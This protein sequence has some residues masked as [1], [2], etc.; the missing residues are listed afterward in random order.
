MSNP[1]HHAPSD[2]PI[3]TRWNVT[4]W[5]DS[6]RARDRE[7]R[8]WV[9]I[10]LVIGIIFTAFPT[11]DTWVSGVF[12][13]WHD[14]SW[15]H[16]IDW[17]MWIYKAVPWFGR[18]ALLWGLFC[19]FAPA[20]W[21]GGTRLKRR[22]AILGLTMFLLVGAAVNGGFKSYWGRA[23]PVAVT[24]FDGDKP[25]T[26]ALIPAANCDKN[27][28]FVSGHAATGYALIAIGALGAARTRR[29]WLSIGLAAGIFTG[30]LRVLQG[31][32]FLSDI[33]FA[34]L[35]VWLGCWLIRYAWIRLR[36]R[37]IRRLRRAA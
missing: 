20:K 33:L 1:S 18:A 29:K 4:R 21:C 8:W 34:G 25:F 17:V 6:T 2:R 27:C 12:W 22:C 19:V 16:N 32:H 24:Q 7:L 9:S 26:P 3:P 30:M 14:Q 28:S 10:F 35:T 37:R 31:G 36:L 15:Q 23:R 13:H 5:L 11:L